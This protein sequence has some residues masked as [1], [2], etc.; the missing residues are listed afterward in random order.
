METSTERIRQTHRPQLS[1]PWMCARPTIRIFFYTDS[2]N[3]NVELLELDVDGF[4]IE[5]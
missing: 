1:R 4:S 3:F 2:E 5:L